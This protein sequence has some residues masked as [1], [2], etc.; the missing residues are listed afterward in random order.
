MTRSPVWLFDLDNTLHNAS[1]HI[2]PHINRAMTAYVAEHLNVAEAEANQLRLTYWRRYGAT[3][4]GLMRHHGID[5]HH[6]L[7]HTH[8]F[9]HLRQDLVFDRAVKAMLHRLPGRKILFSN[10]PRHYA[11]AVLDAMGIAGEFDTIWCLEQLV[12]TP[13]PFPSAF[14]RLLRRENLN[15]NRCIMVEDSA[16]NLRTAKRLG[17]GT[18]LISRDSRTP[19]WV[20]LRLTSVLQLPRAMRG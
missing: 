9:P 12:F 11:A 15:A 16:E 1:V 14:R 2:F 3:L 10:S 4:T 20:N 18:V 7:W 17:M 5:P 6:F 8:Q 13:K 19:A